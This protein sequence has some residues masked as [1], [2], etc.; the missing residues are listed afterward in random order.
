MGI[1]V[2]ASGSSSRRQRFRRRRGLG[3]IADVVRLDLDTVRTCNESHRV[4]FIDRLSLGVD[5]DE[6]AAIVFVAIGVVEVVGATAGLRGQGTVEK[7]AAGVAGLIAAT[8]TPAT[9]T[10]IVAATTITVAAATT[11]TTATT[12]TS[13]GRGRGRGGGGLLFGVDAALDSSPWG[14]CLPRW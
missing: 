13:W 1:Q 2:R 4:G 3:E 10:S 7:A 9:A 11:A 6:D 12:A 8:V 5:V 14:S